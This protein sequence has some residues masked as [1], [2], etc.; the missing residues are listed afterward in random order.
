VLKIAK[1]FE[2]HELTEEE[3]H[4]HP[5]DAEQH[6]FHEDEVLE[7]IVKPVNQLPKIRYLDGLFH[8]LEEIRAE[9]KVG[10]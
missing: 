2:Q 3:A 7:V 5:K 4:F 8:A 1:R 6:L 10:G 9:L